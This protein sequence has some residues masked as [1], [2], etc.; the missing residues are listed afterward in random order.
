[1]K[2]IVKHHLLPLFFTLTLCASSSSFA[3][4]NCI[5]I[6]RAGLEACTANYNECVSEGTSSSTCTS[7]RLECIAEVNQLYTQCMQNNPPE[8]PPCQPGEECFTSTRTNLW[9]LDQPLTF[10]IHF[11]FPNAEKTVSQKNTGVTL[12]IQPSPNDNLNKL[13]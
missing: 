5:Q 1:M 12:F 13:F 6:Q 4:N 3:A 11:E 10:R 9:K 2:F 8:E 7:Q